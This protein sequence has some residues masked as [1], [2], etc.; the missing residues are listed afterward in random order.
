[1]LIHQQ[2]DDQQSVVKRLTTTRRKAMTKPVNDHEQFM[3]KAT[4]RRV[5]MINS[6][7][8]GLIGFGHAVAD[9]ANAVQ[10]T[11]PPTSQPAPGFVPPPPGPYGASPAQATETPG[12]APAPSRTGMTREEFLEQRDAHRKALQEQMQQRQAQYQ[13]RSPEGTAP[14]ANAPM[15]KEEMDKRWEQMRAE[16]EKRMQEAMSAK[17]MTREDMQKQMEA[18]RSER[19]QQMPNE[20]QQR[21]ADERNR[22]QAEY[23]AMQAKEAELRSLLDQVREKQREMQEMLAGMNQERS[24]QTA[25]TFRPAERQPTTAPQ[26]TQPAAPAPQA[27]AAYPAQRP[28]MPYG[29][30]YGYPPVPYGYYNRAPMPAYPYAQPGVP[31]EA[32][33]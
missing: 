8:V 20:M 16:H 27:Q 3:R 9:Q 31:A 32:A 28:A 26:A 14:A 10:P 6:L 2:S 1:M 7:L 13:Q 22:H 30:A 21:M 24:A 29:Q 4:T 33:R 12:F 25:A 11:R 18:M 5:V 15:T 19:E 23:E 17:P